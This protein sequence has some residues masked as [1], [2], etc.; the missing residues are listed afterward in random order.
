MP[1]LQLWRV[2]SINKFLDQGLNPGT[3]HWEHAG[4][5]TGPPAKSLCFLKRKKY[6]KRKPVL[7]RCL[8]LNK[9]PGVD[10][11]TAGSLRV[12]RMD[13]CI[14][15][16]RGIFKTNIN[17]NLS[18]HYHFYLLLLFRV[19]W[20]FITPLPLS[21]IICHSE[22]YN[23][24]AAPLSLS[25]NHGNRA[26]GSGLRCPSLSDGNARFFV[27]SYVLWG[28]ISD[29]SLCPSRHCGLALGLLSLSISTWN[30]K[31]THSSRF[32]WNWHGR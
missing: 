21:P 22:G 4:L 32:W 6:G 24:N 10:K 27:N 5:A 28:P 13:I 19:T 30:M 8:T 12:C 7:K 2:G 9:E 31:G 17:L 23:W 26:R 20:G 11:S 1:G 18:R 16:H 14:L 25:R 29:T 3:L 15:H